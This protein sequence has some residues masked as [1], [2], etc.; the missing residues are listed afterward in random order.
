VLKKVLLYFLPRT[1]LKPERCRFLIPVDSLKEH[2]HPH[3]H[4][5]L[6]PTLIYVHAACRVAGSLDSHYAFSGYL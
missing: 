6:N 4:P 5:H 2:P 3:Q 1:R